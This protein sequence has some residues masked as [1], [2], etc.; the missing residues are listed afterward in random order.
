MIQVPKLGALAVVLR[1]DCALL[2]QRKNPPDAGTWGFAGGHVEFG[3][4]FAEAAVRE[5]FEETGVQ[6]KPVQLIETAEFIHRDAQGE[7]THHF[8]LGAVLCDYVSGEPVADDDA[9]DAAWVPLEDIYAK[10][11]PMS[12]KVDDMAR[13]A[14][15]FL[16]K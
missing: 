16:A 5:L 7:V 2:V 15:A 13:M 12:D 8:V 9:L 14:A 3:E 4:T 6:A 1:D 10:R 11:L